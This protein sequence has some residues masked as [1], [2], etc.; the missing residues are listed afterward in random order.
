ME[1]LRKCIKCGL[2]A[3]NKEDLRLFTKHKQSTFG[4]SNICIKCKTEYKRR[5][6]KGQRDGPNYKRSPRVLKQGRKDNINYR[7]RTRKKV[8]ELY[9]NQ[10]VCCGETTYE[11]LTLDHIKGKGTKERKRLKGTYAVY[12]KAIRDFKSNKKEALNTYRIL[13]WNCNCSIGSYGYCPHHKN[14]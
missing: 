12:L 5:W 11:F 14:K 10:C 7:R 1:Y 4:Y 13:C 2:E 6:A 3:H 8:M 9:G